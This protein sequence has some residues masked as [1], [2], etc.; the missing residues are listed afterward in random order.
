M[1]RTTGFLCGLKLDGKA[2]CSCCYPFLIHLWAATAA[3]TAAAA[4]SRIEEGSHKGD[5]ECDE[6][7]DDEDGGGEISDEVEVKGE[8][9]PIEWFEDNWSGI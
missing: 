3:A 2:C 6:D 4:R 1:K 9:S 5:E 7:D 8:A